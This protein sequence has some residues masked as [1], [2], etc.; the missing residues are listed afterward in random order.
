M[1]LPLSLSI[2]KCTHVGEYIH[3]EMPEEGKPTTEN[4]MRG[5][6]TP[7]KGPII[8]EEN[9]CATKRYHDTQEELD[10]AERFHESRASL[11]IFLCIFGLEL[12]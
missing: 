12:S 6:M 7:A 8:E 2:G 5:P 9:G 1:R 10:H 3:A 11:R 4:C